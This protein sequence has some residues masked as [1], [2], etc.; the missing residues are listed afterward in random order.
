MTWTK[1]KSLTI[2]CDSMFLYW[3]D[4]MYQSGATPILDDEDFV[5][6]YFEGSGHANALGEC[7][8]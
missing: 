7:E 6:P 8:E 5:S 4:S 1:W 3:K 2:V